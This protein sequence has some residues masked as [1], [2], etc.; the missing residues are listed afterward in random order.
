MSTLDRLVID[1]DDFSRYLKHAGPYIVM[2]DESI[3]KAEYPAEVWKDMTPFEQADNRFLYAV[4]AVQ[5]RSD[6]GN[7]DDAW[8]RLKDLR[9]RLVDSSRLLFDR[10]KPFWHST[11]ALSHLYGLFRVECGWRRLGLL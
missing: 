4:S 10:G 11:N 8:E 7:A 2:I 3:K 9:T 6:D 1:D 5:I